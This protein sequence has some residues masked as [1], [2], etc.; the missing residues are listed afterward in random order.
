M[1]LYLI[2]VLLAVATLLQTAFNV[3]L[4]AIVRRIRKQKSPFYIRK[5]G[6]RFI[7]ED[8]E[9]SNKKEVS[10]Y[11]IKKENNKQNSSILQ[12][13]EIEP[14]NIM[15][16]DYRLADKIIKYCSTNDIILEKGF[17]LDDLALNIGTNR[18]YISRALNKAIQLNF[19]QLKNY[20]RV[21]KACS[22]FINNP[23]TNLGALFE[24]SRFSSFTTFSNAFNKHT[25]FPPN[26]WCKDVI[27]RISNSENVGV[28][29]YLP[30]LKIKNQ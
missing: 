11:T 19:N 25:H 10:Y 3:A 2:I 9:A 16:E 22:H 17:Q 18:Y 1:Y 28:Y 15:S 21:Y 24:I 29:D 27:H 14:L 13:K 23:D 20:F 6:K 30:H 12:E 7:I 8:L 26:K 5:S 4:L